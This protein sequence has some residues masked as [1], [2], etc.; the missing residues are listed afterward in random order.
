VTDAGGRFPTARFLPA[1]VVRASRRRLTTKLTTK[2]TDRLG[3][4]R[5]GR[6]G[7]QA[8][9]NTDGL[10]RHWADAAQPRWHSEGQGFESPRVHQIPYSQR[11]PLTPFPRLSPVSLTPKLT[12]KPCNAAHFGGNRDG[13]RLRR[14]DGPYG[15]GRAPEVTP[16]LTARSCTADSSRLG[17]VRKGSSSPGD[18]APARC[19]RGREYRSFRSLEGGPPGTSRRVVL[20]ADYKCLAASSCQLRATSQITRTPKWPGP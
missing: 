11:V 16:C 3:S 5:T 20:E 1:S 9:L 2:L 4:G 17:E 8:I 10:R 12:P 6:D 18:E 15:G 14:P 13:R 7:G 19:R